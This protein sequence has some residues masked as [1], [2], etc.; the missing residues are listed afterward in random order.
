VGRFEEIGSDRGFMVA[1]AKKSD[2]LADLANVV[3]KSIAEGKSIQWF[4]SEFKEIV[5][6]HG[7][8]GWTGEGTKKGEAW[9]TKTIYRT[10]MQT[11][12]SAGRFVQLQEFPIWIYKHFDGQ[13]YPRPHHVS[14]DGLALPKGH[15][16]WKAHYP[17]QGFGC[18]CYVVG[19]LTERS[20][21]RLGGDLDKALPDDWDAINPK[22]GTPFGID[23][24]WDYAPGRS[25]LHHFDKHAATPDCLDFDITGL[26]NKTV[27]CLKP[28]ANQRSWQDI[29]RPDL[30]AVDAAF[31]LAMPE[32]LDYKQ[33]RQEAHDL[34][35]TVLGVS[36]AQPTRVIDTPI[37][38]AIIHYDLLEHMVEKETDRRER[39]ANFIL[40]T[41]MNPFEIWNTQ[42]EDS[43]RRR[44]I[45]L[46]E[47]KTDLL[48]SIRV[49]KDG[50][51]FWNMMHTDSRKTNRQR[52]GEL[53]YAMDLKDGD[54]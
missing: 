3:D 13:R 8:T 6:R 37:E 24:N 46:F 25:V 49:N 33:T 34:L 29:N 4:R 20:A 32:I 15:P 30:R 41:L 47:G 52:I 51:I 38:K 40:P 5:A 14:W 12:Y 45:G 18:D 48:V 17:P 22:T 9:R 19:A 16:F 2:L 28:K 53:I 39:Y 7:W 54:A 11:S 21:R 35:A 42:Y 10:N 27:N 31:K 26:T 50:S 23:K 43:L 36:A 1:G 44:Y